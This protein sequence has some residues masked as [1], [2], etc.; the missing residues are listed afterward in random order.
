MLNHKG[1]QEI[2][3]ERLLGLNRIEATHAVNNPA[4]GRVL[5]KAGFILEGR[6]KEYHLC[7]SG[8]E[9]NDLYGLTRRTYESTV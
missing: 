9:D 7:N 1:T 3:T 4:S 2:K 5:Q 8:F 6:A